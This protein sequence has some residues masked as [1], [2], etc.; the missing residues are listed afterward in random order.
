MLYRKHKIL[1]MRRRHFSHILTHLAIFETSAE[2]KEFALN[3]WISTTA[4][5]RESE[6]L[7][8]V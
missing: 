4:V 5:G 2:S 1:N 7:K 6:M 3:L 8:I